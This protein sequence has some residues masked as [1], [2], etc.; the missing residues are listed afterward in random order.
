MNDVS[1]P[2]AGTNNHKESSSVLLISLKSG[3]EQNYM[4]AHSLALYYYRPLLYSNV[5][6]VYKDIDIVHGTRCET[7][8]PGIQ[9]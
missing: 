8:E 6:L 7:T 1:Y 5:F 3:L 2:V 9:A 4:H